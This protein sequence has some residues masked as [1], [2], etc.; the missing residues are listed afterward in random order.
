VWV[1]TPGP[2]P[3]PVTAQLADTIVRRAPA[4]AAL[5]YRSPIFGVEYVNASFSSRWRFGLIFGIY[6]TVRGAS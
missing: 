6:L 3:E 2:F 4:V 1:L 5:T